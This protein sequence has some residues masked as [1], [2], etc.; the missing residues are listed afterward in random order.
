M[1][2]FPQ[3]LANI[4][5]SVGMKVPENADDFDK[6]EFPHFQVYLSVQLGTAMPNPGAAHENATVIAAL[7]DDQIRK[8]TVEDLRKLGFREGHSK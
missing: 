8:V 5:K 1:I 3:L 7:S 4:A 6:N 2:A